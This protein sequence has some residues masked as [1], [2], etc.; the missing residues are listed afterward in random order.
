MMIQINISETNKSFL[1]TPPKTGSMHANIIF[2]LFSFE[3]RECNYDRTEISVLDEFPKHTHLLDI[4]EGHENYTL[5]CTARNPLTMIL[6][7][8]LY[9]PLRGS[10]TVDGFREFFF[11]EKSKSNTKLNSMRGFKRVPDFFLRVENLYE[12]YKKLPFLENNPFITCG[13]LEEI[14]NKKINI[15]KNHLNITDCYTKDMIDYVYE[16]NKEY[17]NLL[18]YKPEL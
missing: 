2:S 15:N 11:E 6:S 5:I 14:C 18:N 9:S 7:S 10:K 4:F 16:I 13:V 1:W 8:Y 3:Y 12:D 17:F